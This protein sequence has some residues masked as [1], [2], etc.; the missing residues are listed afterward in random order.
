MSTASSSGDEFSAYNFSEFTEEDLQRVDADVA[1]I[2]QGSP[3]ITI[4]VEAPLAGGNTSGTI[5]SQTPQTSESRRKGK[6]R[7]DL[8]PLSPMARHRRHGTLSVTDLASLTWCEV[9]FEYGLRQ[10]R[11][12]PIAMRPQSFISA[13]GKEISVAKEVA[14]KN[15][16]RTKQGKALHKILEREVKTEE[17]QVEISSEEEQWGLRL[18]NMLA[19][20]RG[21][22]LEGYTRELPVFGILQDEVVVGIID[23]V[24]MKTEM[25]TTPQ[26]R[27]SSSPT[28]STPK[29]LRR[30]LSPPQHLVTEYF[31]NTTPANPSASVDLDAPPAPTEREIERP[32]TPEGPSPTATSPRKF[33][34]L[35][36][37]KTRKSNSL[38]ANRDTFPSRIQLMLY[39]RLLEDLTS[40]SPPFD[41]AALW[42]RVGVDPTQTF[43]PKFLVQ[44]GLLEE[45]NTWNASCLSDLSNAYIG[46]VQDLNIAGV[47]TKLELVYRLLQGDRNKGKKSRGVSRSASPVVT[48]EERDLAKAIEASLVDARASGEPAAQ[49]SSAEVTVQVDSVPGTDTPLDVATP[50]VGLKNSLQYLTVNGNN[51][52]GHVNPEKSD[53]APRPASS[54]TEVELDKHDLRPIGI[55]SFEYDEEMLNR[56][57]IHTLK[58]WRGDRNPQGVSL[59]DS[60]R[61]RTCEYENNCEWREQKALEVQE[62]LF[63]R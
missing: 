62:R 57:I 15:D 24:I 41:F 19:S 46:M 4:Q 38:P 28:R 37:T 14:L 9:Q 51:V 31:P 26:K 44:A 8:N 22:L 30:S 27:S 42:Q 3:Q 6:Q 13:Q 16:V 1:R 10:Q 63:G 35:Q 25:P 48:Q 45:N 49:K 59:E 60:W 36:D 54:N 32:S 17:L 12:M 56:H 47:D 18:V 11:H 2:S 7:A 50:T 53:S 20:L 5:M 43:S 61:C 21:I 55:K 40:L 23:E 34:H 39:Y 29:K 58:W 52:E 33:L